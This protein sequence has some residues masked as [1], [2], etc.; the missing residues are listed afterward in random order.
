MFSPEERMGAQKK[1]S[2]ASHQLSSKS[3]LAQ[4]RFAES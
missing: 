3:R 4:I 2:A 1:P